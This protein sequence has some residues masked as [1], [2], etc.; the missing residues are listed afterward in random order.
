M[1][2]F[3]AFEAEEADSEAVIELYRKSTGYRSFP[4][5]TTRPLPG[6]VD[7]RLVGITPASRLPLFVTT[8]ETVSHDF[9]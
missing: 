5:N 1:A 2:A 4:G 6:M 3:L 8:A 9:H 7:P